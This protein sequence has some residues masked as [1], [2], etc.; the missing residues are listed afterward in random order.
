[1][2]RFVKF[3]GYSISVEDVIMVKS[4]DQETAELYF[5]N[6]PGSITIHGNPD[7]LMELI[8]TNVMEFDAIMDKVKAWTKEMVEE[9]QG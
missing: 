1:M 2:K 5:R 8:S 9:L 4:V 6:A 7:E 3:N